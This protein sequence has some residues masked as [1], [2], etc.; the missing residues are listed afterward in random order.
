VLPEPRYSSWPNAP[1]HSYDQMLT[2]GYTAFKTHGRGSAASPM[3][4]GARAGQ[5]SDEDGMDF[6]P[7]TAWDVDQEVVPVLNAPYAPRPVDSG[8]AIGLNR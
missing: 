3:G 6:D 4:M 7:D 5:R 8:P 2:E 1:P